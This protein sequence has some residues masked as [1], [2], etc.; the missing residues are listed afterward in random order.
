MLQ[1]N[2][3]FYTKEIGCIMFL[4]RGLFAIV[5]KNDCTSSQ[6]P[7]VFLRKQIN[8]NQ[9]QTQTPQKCELLNVFYSELLFLIEIE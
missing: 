4:F 5:I 7:D 9:K 8:K 3:A 1:S 6:Q 2:E